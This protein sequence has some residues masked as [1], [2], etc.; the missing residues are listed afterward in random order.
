MVPADTH[1]KTDCPHVCIGPA[2]TGSPDTF[3]NGLPALRV[4]DTGIHALCCG[5]NIWVAIAGS[6]T[7]LINNLPA[8]RIFDADMH[9]GGPGYMVEGS[10]DVLVGG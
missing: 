5:P 8:H 1:Y 9:C 4:T 10:P 3:V 7:V 2:E 6:G